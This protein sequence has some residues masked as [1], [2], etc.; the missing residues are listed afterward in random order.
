MRIALTTPTGQIGSSTVRNLLDAGHTDLVLLV[1]DASKLPD[2]VRDAT[3]TR[4]GVQ[5][6]A[7]FVREATQGADALLWISPPDWST[8]SV[9][10]WYEALGRVAASAVESNGIARVVHVSSEGAQDHDSHGPVSGLGRIEGLLDATGAATRHLRPTFFFENF[11]A[12]IPAI[13]NAGSVFFPVPT[14]T[15]TGMIATGDIAQVATDL[16]TA[17]FQG[18]HIVPLHGARD[19]SYDEAAAILSD[20]LGREVT[21]QQIPV[22]ALREQLASMGAT[23]AWLSGFADLYTSIGSDGYRG[24]PR[25]AESTT[26]T[27]LE[28]WARGT[29]APMLAQ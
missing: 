7:D 14:T 23:T 27:S 25:T 3:Q 4:E 26:P 8:D 5:Q 15:T 10:D 12:Q 16:L 21:A 13:Q 17:D 18:Q 28:A 24:E 11:K 6:D 20:A 19:Y 2:D 9:F 22:E 1:R 29:F